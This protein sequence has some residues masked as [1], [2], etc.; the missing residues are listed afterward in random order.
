MDLKLLNTISLPPLNKYKNEQQFLHY[1]KTEEVQVLGIVKHELKNG[2]SCLK[3]S[4]NIPIYK[5]EISLCPVFKPSHRQRNYVLNTVLSHRTHT[6]KKAN[7]SQPIGKHPILHP[8]RCES[9]YK[10]C[11][12]QSAH[13]LLERV[14]RTGCPAPSSLCSFVVDKPPAPNFPPHFALVPGTR[15]S[16]A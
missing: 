15:G 6:S 16:Q 11:T 1:C 7:T 8:Y 5:L 12:N 3:V 13:D 14:R 9:V 2:E 4:R 10:P